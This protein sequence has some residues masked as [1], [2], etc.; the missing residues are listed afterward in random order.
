M[1]SRASLFCPVDNTARLFNHHQTSKAT[2]IISI[3][4]TTVGLVIIATKFS[5]QPEFGITILTN[6]DF[7][8]RYLK[9]RHTP[10]PAP[11]MHGGRP[12]SSPAPMI[13]VQLVSDRHSITTA[14]V[15]VS[16]NLWARAEPPHIDR[17]FSGNSS[18]TLGAFSARNL[19]CN[20]AN[21][22]SS[23]SHSLSSSSSLSLVS[24]PA[25][26]ECPAGVRYTFLGLRRASFFS[27]VSTRAFTFLSPSNTLQVKSGHSF[28]KRYTCSFL[29]PV[30]FLPSS[31]FHDNR[32]VC[33]VRC[34]PSVSCEDKF[35]TGNPHLQHL[36]SL[37]LAEKCPTTPHI[38]HLRVLTCTEATPPLTFSRVTH[39]RFPE[40]FPS[41]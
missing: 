18:L 41:R 17:S 9:H 25:S 23:S 20:C 11:C 2:T 30:F 32:D 33:S 26:P 10:P 3:I 39:R 35:V 21:G 37:Q 16:L 19:L 36:R 15:L 38:Q 22:I 31:R 40:P 29:L 34:D 5:L 8:Q 6:S 12:H 24:I 4:P 28:S 7:N 13:N 27:P 1:H 14:T